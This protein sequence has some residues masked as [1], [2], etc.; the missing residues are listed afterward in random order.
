MRKC[1]IPEEP[2]SIRVS[3][4]ER[5]YSIDIGLSLWEHLAGFIELVLHASRVVV[6]SDDIVGPIYEPKLAEAFEGKQW[7]TTYHQMPAG[8]L[9]KNLATV[10]NLYTEILDAGCD[11]KTP[12]VALGGG[13]V[14]D[15]A[16]F[17]AATLLRGLPFIQAPA[18][19]LAMVDSS[20]GGKTGVDMPQGKNL[21]GAFYQPC[22]V[23]ISVDTLKTLPVRELRAG[24]AEVIKYGIIWD[25]DFFT[26]LEAKVDALMAG[27]ESERIKIIRRCCEIKAEMVSKDEHEGGLREILNFGHT[28]GHAIETVAGYGHLLHGEAVAIG[29]LIET[30]IA[31]QRGMVPASLRERL[32]ILLQRTSLPV[33]P[34]TCDLDRIW[35]LMHA[36]KKARGGSIRMVLPT[37]MGQVQTLSGIARKEFEVAWR[38]CSE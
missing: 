6:I 23:I 10:Q 37:A 34:P 3:L 8:E 12:I 35:D 2:E 4:G 38:T 25:S 27:D 11:R 32:R 18:T 16:G 22:R 14:G 33:T 19:L 24:M 36:D 21:V 30:A 7:R 17:I 13:V 5:S 29:M 15:T 20:V 1:Q 26:D 31:E 9:N 28:A